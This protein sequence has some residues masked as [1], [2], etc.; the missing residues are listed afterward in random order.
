ML[1]QTDGRM[2]RVSK[3]IHLTPWNT[4]FWISLQILIPESPQSDVM[5]TMVTN[6]QALF[7]SCL[8]YSC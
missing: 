8:Y 5:S 7:T 6:E 1:T 4:N 3:K 2:D